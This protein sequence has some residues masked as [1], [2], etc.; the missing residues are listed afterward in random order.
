MMVPANRLLLAAA[1]IAVPAATI[2]GFVPPA[3]PVCLAILVATAAAALIDAALAQRRIQSIEAR[4]P[5]VLRLT[6]N[7]PATVL[8]TLLNSSRTI[9][10][11]TLWCRPPAQPMPFEALPGTG[12]LAYPV[13]VPTRGDHP[14]TPL[15]LE[16]PSPLGLWRARATLPLDCTLRVYPN[17]R[18]RAT[19]ALFLRTADLGVR[20]HRQVG[21]GREFDNLRHYMPGDSFEDVSW[22]ATARRGFPTVKLYRVENAQ[23]IYAVVD[24]SRLSGR[25][26]IL[27]AYVDAALHLALV[28]QSQHDRFGLVTFSDRTNR[29]VRARNGMDHFRLCR[30]TIYNLQPQRVSPDFREVFTSLQLNLRRRSLLVFFTSLDDALLAETFQ[31]DVSMLARRHLVLVNV[32]HPPGLQP[33]FTGE[34]PADLDSLYAGLAG[35]LVSNRMRELQIALQNHGVRMSIVDPARIKAQVT[36]QYLDVKR[37]QAL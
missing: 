20:L 7:V 34:P 21:K 4:A 8:I 19:A 5:Q 18:D 17:L 26:P 24:A 37:R 27:E 31:H 30:E 9:L 1:V 25:E 23:E 35:Q 11:G 14:F 22:K 28:A 13:T 29:F 16:S 36:S 2:A 12:V 33:L 15:F 6:K 32:M 10:S 3:A